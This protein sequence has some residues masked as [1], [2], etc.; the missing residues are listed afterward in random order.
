M[1]FFLHKDL[2]KFPF[3]FIIRSTATTAFYNEEQLD[4]K[5]EENAN[6]TVQKSYRQSEGNETSDLAAIY[7]RK[8]NFNYIR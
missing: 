2:L 1:V 6:T 5:A 4:A 7:E 3:G 8:I